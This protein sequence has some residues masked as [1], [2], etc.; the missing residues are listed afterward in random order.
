MSL[1]NFFEALVQMDKLELAGV[2]EKPSRLANEVIGELLPAWVCHQM[3]GGG[4]GAAVARQSQWYEGRARPV[5]KSE[6]KLGTTGDP[7]HQSQ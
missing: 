2:P 4:P 3:S 5:E 1:S 7:C 6:G